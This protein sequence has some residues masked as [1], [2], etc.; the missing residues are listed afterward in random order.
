MWQEILK[1]A[2]LGTERSALAVPARS[3]ALGEVLSKLD[4]NAREASLL[5]AAAAVALYEHAGQMPVKDA[6][7]LPAPAELNDLPGCNARAAQRLST[8]LTG[9]FEEL[10]PEWFAALIAAQQRVPDEH[11]PAVLQLGKARA[12]LRATIIAAIGQRGLWLAQQNTDWSYVAGEIDVAEWHTATHVARLALLKKMR[13]T[14]PDE[15]RDLLTATWKEDSPK[16]RA[17]F[18]ATFHPNLSADDETF[19]EA[20]LDDRSTLV[21]RAAADLLS[22]LPDSAFVQRMIERAQPLLSFTKKARGKLEIEITL[23]AERTEAM[24]RDGITAKPTNSNLGEKAWWLDNMLRAVPLTNWEEAASATHTDII[25]ACKKH[26]WESLLLEAW[27]DAAWRQN[28]TDWIKA[29]LPLQRQ[30]Y[31]AQQGS[32]DREQLEALLIDLLAENPT[33]NNK[34]PAY[35]LLNAHLDQWGKPLSEAML[36][37][38]SQQ[39]SS[40]LLGQEWYLL[41]RVMSYLDASTIPA[42]I[43]ILT[44]FAGDDAERQAQ[45]K[46]Y[47]DILEFRHAMLKE[48]TL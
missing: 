34:N 8:L 4:A 9:E 44:T 40:R 2:I 1:I 28:R 15:A 18:L 12:R 21:R 22:Y 30:R 32:L 35:G 41:T 42:A 36:Q 11:L 39:L 46:R 19:L 26:E 6:R 33:L 17:E 14:N 45:I 25:N 27:L 24:I 7:A 5:S 3:D 23:P 16:E 47:L 10:L 38:L 37:S 20:A 13:A 29:I 43:H 31:V 48:I